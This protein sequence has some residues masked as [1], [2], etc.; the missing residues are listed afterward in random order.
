MEKYGERWPREAMATR[1]NGH[2]KQWPREAMATREGLSHSFCRRSLAFHGSA[3][4]GFGHKLDVSLTQK[5][6][7][8]WSDRSS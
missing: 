5:M 8:C 2:E 6:G 1:S 4:F 3:S 7:G